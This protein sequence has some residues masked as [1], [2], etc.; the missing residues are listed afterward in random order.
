MPPGAVP[1]TRRIV[2]G[3]TPGLREGGAENE[4]AGEKRGKP[5]GVNRILFSWELGRD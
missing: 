1:A 5:D 4:R 2:L 3:D